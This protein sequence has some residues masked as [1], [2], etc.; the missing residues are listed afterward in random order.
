[1]SKPQPHKP[2]PR[3]SGEM[4]GAADASHNGVSQTGVSPASDDSRRRFVKTGL[5]AGLAALPVVWTLR[6]RPAW[7][8]RPIAIGTTPTAGTTAP[9]PG[10]VEGTDTDTDMV[11]AQARYLFD[12]PWASEGGAMEDDPGLSLPGGSDW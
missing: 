8:R 12:D 3:S 6:S 7:G 10:G 11:D 1:M 2:N 5:K 4:S 9:E